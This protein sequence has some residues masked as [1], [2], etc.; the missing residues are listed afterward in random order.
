MKLLRYG[1]PGQ[2]RPGLLDAE[3]R[4]RD[5]SGQV[6]DIAGDT[7]MT[8]LY[9]LACRNRFPSSV[10]AKRCREASRRSRSEAAMAGWTKISVLGIPGVSS[11]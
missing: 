11:V 10:A 4:L 6:P 1:A 8:F 9:W 7:R 5:L 2:E 3:G